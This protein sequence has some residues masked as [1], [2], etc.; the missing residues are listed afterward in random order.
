MKRPVVGF[1]AP[2]AVSA[3]TIG[4]VVP[5][6]A[7][8]QPADD[9]GSAL[10]DVTDGPGTADTDV[11]ARVADVPTDTL[12]TEAIEATVAGIDAMV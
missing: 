11:L 2:F 4:A 1:V 8:E 9:A 12:S 5:V 10:L 3:L 6:Y 7:D